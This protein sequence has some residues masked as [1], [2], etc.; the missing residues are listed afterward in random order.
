[1]ISDLLSLFPFKPK[2]SSL[3]ILKATDQTRVTKI[4]FGAFIWE[5]PSAL[6]YGKMQKEFA[7]G[8]KYFLQQNKDFMEVLKELTST[9]FAAYQLN[10]KTR[11]LSGRK[12]SS[13]HD[14]DNDANRINNHKILHGFSFISSL[15]F[16]FQ[17]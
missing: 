5:E 15:C 14:P 8:P 16:N 6:P 13:S 17:I 10:R 7:T 3:D 4:E 1:M 2:Q 11:L 12:D 9:R